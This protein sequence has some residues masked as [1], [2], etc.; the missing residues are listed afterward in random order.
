MF[1]DYFLMTSLSLN[2]YMGFRNHVFRGHN[3]YM[4]KLCFLL[5]LMYVGMLI[6]ALKNV[7]LALGLI[8]KN[9]QDIPFAQEDP[10]LGHIQ[11][12]GTRMITA[13]KWFV[14]VNQV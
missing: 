4:D 2:S 1:F 3:A 12:T 14:V 7:H 10:A 5:I 8:A 9:A 11:D 13:M 6:K